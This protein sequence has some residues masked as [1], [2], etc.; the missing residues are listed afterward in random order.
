MVDTLQCL[1]IRKIG[2]LWSLGASVGGPPW[3]ALTETLHS[4]CCLLIWWFCQSGS[5]TLANPGD[6]I[7]A[8]H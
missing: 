2:R 1:E 7:L 8:L 4:R 5:S 6:F 3:H